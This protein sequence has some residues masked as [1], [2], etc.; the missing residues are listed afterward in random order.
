MLFTLQTET[1]TFLYA[2]SMGAVL[3][4]LFDLFR[5]L[6]M[7]VRPT[8]LSA[9]WQDIVFWLAAAVLTYCLLLVRCYGMI[10]GYVLLGELLGFLLCRFTL[11]AVFV[12]LMSYVVRA[13]KSAYIWVKKHITK[14]IAKK[15][16]LFLRF[17]GKKIMIFYRMV[18]NLAKSMKK[19]LELSQGKGV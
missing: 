19:T 17:T 2:V 15:I 6:R 16:R 10:R 4:V 14:P 12:A 1:V 18:K 5:I 13:L 11:S 7:F 9:F 8:T 3:C